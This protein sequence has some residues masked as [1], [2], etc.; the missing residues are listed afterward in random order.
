VFGEDLA[1]VAGGDEDVWPAGE[2]DDWGV[3]VGSS[4][5]E[6]S[7][8][9]G[10]ADADLAAGIDGVVADAPVLVAVDVAGFGFRERGVCL[11]RGAAIECSVGAVGVVDV[12]EP[13]E[14]AVQLV[15]GG[16]RGLSR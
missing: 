13:G 2:D 4:D 7:E 15:E 11:G 3:L 10:V 16:C 8:F 9:A 12:L 1:G 5:A 6:V 14:L